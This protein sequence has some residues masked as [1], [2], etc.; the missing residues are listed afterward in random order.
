[1]NLTQ[2]SPYEGEGSFYE[3]RDLC[4]NDKNEKEP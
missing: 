3:Y 2:P 4:N 1:M